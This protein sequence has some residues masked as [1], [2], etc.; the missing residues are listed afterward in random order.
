LTKISFPL[1]LCIFVLF[2]LTL[3]F[4]YHTNWNWGIVKHALPQG[5]I[6]G[7]MLFLMYIQL[8]V[9]SQYLY[10]NLMILSIWQSILCHNKATSS[11]TVIMM[12]FHSLTKGL[13]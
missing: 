5:S 9:H 1:K 3:H 13:R 2:Y 8:S 6:L 12:H 4:C 11:N 7:H 10:T